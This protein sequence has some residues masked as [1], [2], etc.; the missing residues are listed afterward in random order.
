M[1][2]FHQ[3]ATDT[4]IPIS[5]ENSYLFIN[6]DRIANFL[7]FSFEKNYKYILAKPVQNGFV[8]DWFSSYDNLVNIKEISTLD[9]EQQLIRYWEFID[10]VN[11]KIKKLTLTNDE[12]NKNWANLLTKVFN[13]EDN[14]IFSNGKD[15]CIVWGWKFNNNENYKPNILNRNTDSLNPQPKSE[16]IAG[17]VPEKDSLPEEN[18]KLLEEKINEIPEEKEETVKDFSP[19]ES[20]LEDKE[21][22]NFLK[23]LKWFASK[24]WWLLML[25]LLLIIFGLL[26]KSCNNNDADVNYKL[27]QLEEKANK[28]CN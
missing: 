1:N 25:V 17:K 11:A 18:I 24:F 4:F 27:N 12:N 7:A 6:Y 19:K 26:F 21:K 23:F 22:S 28:C 14:F 13:H 2:K 8:F 5:H 15:I 9:A 10:V 20:I 3:I 16:G